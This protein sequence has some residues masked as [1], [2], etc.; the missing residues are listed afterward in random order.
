MYGTLLKSWLSHEALRGNCAG[1]AT[2]TWK[3]YVR[4]AV[5]MIGITLR[6]R[7]RVT[8]A[9]AVA[10]SSGPLW[11]ASGLAE[12]GTAVRSAADA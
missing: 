3:V 6:K 10:H 8:K 11:P 12:P 4:A 7:P 1:N 2:S 5:A 9:T